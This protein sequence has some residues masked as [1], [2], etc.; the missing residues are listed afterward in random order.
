[1]EDVFGPITPFAITMVVTLLTQWVKNYFT[2][3]D[4]QIQ[5][6]ALGISAFAII[7][8]ELVSK[9]EGGVPLSG[10]LIYGAVIY[11]LMAWFSSIGMYE[12]ASK[13]LAKRE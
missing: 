11:A 8:Y 7:L 12:V 6:V 9:L 3:S 5:L 1:M 4:K 10:M 13:Q 2:L